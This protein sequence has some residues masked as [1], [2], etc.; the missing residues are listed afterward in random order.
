M[1]LEELLTEDTKRHYPI[2]TE[3]GQV[4]ASFNEQIELGGQVVRQGNTVIVF[5]PIAEGVIEH[6]SFNADSSSNLVDFHKKFWRMLDKAGA[7]MATTT[8]ENPKISNL[9]K[10]VANEFDVSIIENDDGTFTS[11]VRF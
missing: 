3:V 4:F 6:H 10:S 8:Y 5:R 2:G 1:T 11:Q 9:I 7:K